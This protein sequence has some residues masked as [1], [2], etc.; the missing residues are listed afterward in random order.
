MMKRRNLCLAVFAVLPVLAVLGCASG[1]I[2]DA[3]SPPNQL[4]VDLTETQPITGTR[5]TVTG[6]CIFQITEWEARFNNEPKNS[7]AT[8]SP[9]NDYFVEQFR[10]TYSWPGAPAVPVPPPRDLPSPGTVK[11]G[12]Q[13]S[14]RFEPILLQDFDP[15]ME[16]TTGILDMMVQARYS[17]GTRVNI[18]L[19]E[20]IV[21]QSCQ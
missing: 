9:F 2:D 10:V 18:P 3:G 7:L 6:N 16:G 15:S 11:P 1:D 4:Q 14:I 13:K 8:E 20:S 12:E 17:D 19:R 5:D 21:I